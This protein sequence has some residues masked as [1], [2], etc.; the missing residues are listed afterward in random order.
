MTQVTTKLNGT[1][2]VTPAVVAAVHRQA[3]RW[4]VVILANR[5]GLSL[6]EATSLDA[7]GQ[8]A[9]L[10]EKHQV[11]RIVRVAPARETVARCIPVPAGSAEEVGAS[12][13]LLAEA[14][15]PESV[16]P[17]RRAAGVIPEADKAPGRAALLIG[18]QGEAPGEFAEEI[19]ESWTTP[20]AA[21]AVLRQGRG[22]S[23]VYA[24]PEEGAMSV[25]VFGATKSLARVLV[26]DAPTPSAFARSVGSVVAETCAAAGVAAAGAPLGQS[27]VVLAIDAG[28]IAAVRA[29]VTGIADQ[30]SWF[31]QY[32]IALGAAMMALAKDPLT[33]GLCAMRASAPVKQESV[34]EKA[35]NWLARPR[36]AW[37]MLAA[38]LAL[39]L[40]GPLAV[41]AGR[42]AILESKAVGLGDRNREKLE[43]AKRSAMYDQLK[44]SRWP[45]S[46]LLADISGAIPVGVSTESIRLASDQGLA[47][48]GTAESA[49]LVNKM[50]ESLTATKLLASVKLN[51]T[52][53]TGDGVEFDVTADVVNPHVKA[54]GVEDFAAKP[55]AVRLY[56]DGAVN[57]TMPKNKGKEAAPAREARTT[58]RAPV[59]RPERPER[60]NNNG[61]GGGDRG[62]DRGSRSSEAPS[63]P[64]AS[65]P[66]EAPPPLTDDQISKMD[67]GAAT[68]EWVARKTFPQKN[69]TVDAA[70]K[71]RLEEEV[72]KL[73]EQM[74]KAGGTK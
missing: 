48:Q 6:V 28:V 58:S 16:A 22:A 45:M 65:P 40:L 41:S 8:I 9:P 14:Q 21:L 34:P 35:V 7:D 3:D 44:V 11:E 43:S 10:L 2:P 12:I 66:G 59:D 24:D 73:R 30:R 39:L 61:G 31:D 74:D 17:H 49:D 51:R 5:N 72:R 52:E 4:R 19:E 47:I 57:T 13:G 62:S 69:P 60:N 29:S 33:R 46:K 50:M 71:S 53:A 37:G 1:T 36:N 56:G 55:L 15:L 20:A 54:A 25:L 38:S 70:T 67:R 27:G 64:A 42:L 18:W 23:A 68:K 26:E 32:G 63:R